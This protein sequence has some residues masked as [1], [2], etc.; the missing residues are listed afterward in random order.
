[1]SL[2]NEHVGG[3]GV[4]AI[5]IEGA[6]VDNYHF[7]IVATYVNTGDTYNLTL[8][9]DSENNS[10]HLTSYGDWLQ[11]YEE[12]HPT[13][14]YWRP[15]PNTLVAM[16]RTVDGA[17]LAA[18]AFVSDGRI[19]IGFSRPIR[20]DHENE[21][22]PGDH[23]CVRPHSSTVGGGL[24]YER[25]CGI[26]QEVGHGWDVIDV[27]VFSEPGSANSPRSDPFVDFSV[28][29]FDVEP[30]PA[31]EGNLELFR[32]HDQDLDYRGPW[33]Y[34]IENLAERRFV[35]APHP[36]RLGDDQLERLLVAIDSFMEAG[37]KRQ[38]VS[39]FL[40]TP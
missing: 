8:V 34:S 15:D 4:E 33:A 38:P 35:N 27:R 28:Y 39:E 12:E 21:F 6:H 13:E 32:D 2:V 5:R 17:P 24:S 37:M 23:V 25:F 11:A 31:F 9:H 20:L 19:E 36:V 10:F 40:K 26:V 3:S 29:S 14:C 7:D 1:M 16:L 22:L 18:H 30:S